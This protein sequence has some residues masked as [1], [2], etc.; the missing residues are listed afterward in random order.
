MCSDPDDV[1]RRKRAEVG[2]LSHDGGSV[3]QRGG[4]DPDV[5]SA[6][7]TAGA[8]LFIGDPRKA[9]CRLIVDWQRRVLAADGESV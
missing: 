6:E 8:E 7:L 9:R 4:S 2:I 1:Y 5:V 3:T